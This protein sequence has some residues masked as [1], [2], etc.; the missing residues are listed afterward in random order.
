MSMSD[1]VDANLSRELK[2]HMVNMESLYSR[3]IAN[4]FRSQEV[5]DEMRKTIVRTASTLMQ[6][7]IPLE[8]PKKERTV[9]DILQE[10]ATE[11]GML[12]GSKA[13]AQGVSFFRNVQDIVNQPATPKEKIVAEEEITIFEDQD[14]NFFL[15]DEDGNEIECDEWG[16]PLEE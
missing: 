13:V 6:H 4:P 15:I 5:I 7:N 2:E 14:G 10:A 8:I 11:T 12:L 9:T 3:M 16:D 1:V